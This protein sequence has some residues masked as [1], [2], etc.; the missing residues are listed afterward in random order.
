VGDEAVRLQHLI[1]MGGRSDNPPVRADAEEVIRA[2]KASIH[3]AIGSEL[4]PGQRGQS[5]S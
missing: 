1:A 4:F 2:P 3:R 5:G